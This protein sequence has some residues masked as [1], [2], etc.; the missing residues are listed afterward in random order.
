MNSFNI[1]SASNSHVCHLFLSS[2]ASPPP[3]SLRCSL[4][5]PKVS[6]HYLRTHRVPCASLI[7]SLL[8]SFIQKI[9]SPGTPQSFKETL[10]STALSL[11]VCVAFT[12]M[13]RISRVRAE[14]TQEEGLL[15]YPVLRVGTGQASGRGPSQEDKG[16]DSRGP[17]FSLL[18]SSGSPGHSPRRCRSCVSPD[19]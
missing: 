1:P 17:S 3:G 18:L 4:L 12:H 15:N 2:P 8:C 11:C 10:L 5:P 16:K 13:L 9:T 14:G 19:K 7:H 6:T